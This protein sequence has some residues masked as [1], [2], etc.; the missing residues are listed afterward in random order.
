MLK[1]TNITPIMCKCTGKL[2][3]CL[4]V[5]HLNVIERFGFFVIKEIANISLYDKNCTSDQCLMTVSR[6]IIK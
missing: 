2:V 6:N 4:Y 3:V 1:G 5:F